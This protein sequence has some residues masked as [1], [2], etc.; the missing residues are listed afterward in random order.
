MIKSNKSFLFSVLFCFILSASS[1][2]QEDD[3][4]DEEKSYDTENQDKISKYD[5]D[6]VELVR[7]KKNYKV[8]DGLTFITKTGNLNITQSVQTLYNV[9]TPDDFESYLSEFRIRRARMKLSGNAFDKKIYYRIRLDFAAN[10]QSPTSGDRSYNP[11]LQDAY[12]EYRP[13]SNQRI[14]LGLRADYIDTREIRFEGEVLGF[15]ERSPI[16]GA[17]DAIF[18]Y[19]L[20]YSASFRVYNKQLIKPYVSITTGEGNAALSQNFGGLKYG[21]RLDYLPFGSFSKLGEFYMEDRAR[22]NKPKL[23]FGGIYSYADDASSAK[24][25]NGGRWIYGDINQKEMYP[26]YIKYGV[27]Y[28]FKYRG[29]Y[30]IGTIVKTEAKVPTGI[31]GEFSLSG[32]FTPYTNQTPQQIEDKVRSRLNLGYGYN[33]QAGYLLPSEIAFGLRYS[34]MVQDE[35]SATFSAYDNFYTLVTTKYFAGNSLKLQGEIGYQEY[36]V[37]TL[38]KGSYLAQL[39]LTIEL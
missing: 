23:V 12:V 5:F 39:M 25:A 22:E 26:D 6:K 24:G 10:Y 20:R 28:L 21:I 35:K 33:F 4:Q 19:G 11:V 16:P 17:F 36:T 31:A 1:W 7:I 15:V 13:T 9:A 37:P 18:D 38:A 27:D 30:S 3:L 14:S 29:F 8:G 32:N 34:H 2:A